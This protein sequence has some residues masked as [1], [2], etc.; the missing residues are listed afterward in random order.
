MEEK[1]H[2]NKHENTSTPVQTDLPSQL[3]LQLY[4]TVEASSK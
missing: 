2:W 1:R 3:Q 4:S